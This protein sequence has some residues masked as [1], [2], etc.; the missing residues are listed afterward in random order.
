M[1]DLVIVTD[2]AL[3]HLKKSLNSNTQNV[4]M[5]FFLMLSSLQEKIIFAQYF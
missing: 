4:L 3:L 5:L 1:T 2:S